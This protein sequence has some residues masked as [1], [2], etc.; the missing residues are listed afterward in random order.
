MSF[1]LSWEKFDEIKQYVT[2]E[3]IKRGCELPPAK[4]DW[5]RIKGYWETTC[6]L[7][8][9]DNYY[10]FLARSADETFGLGIIKYPNL[11]TLINTTIKY[12]KNYK[13]SI[14]TKALSQIACLE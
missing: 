11:K 3:L 5:R 2:A 9:A 12:D 6:F 14:R 10:L 8:N 7:H 1:F 13:D 4:Q